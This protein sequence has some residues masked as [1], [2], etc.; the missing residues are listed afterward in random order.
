MSSTSTTRFRVVPFTALHA[1][2]IQPQKRQLSEHRFFMGVDWSAYAKRGSAYAMEEKGL[3]IA[4]AG[5]MPVWDGVYEAWAMIGSQ[6]GRAAMVRVYKETQLFLGFLFDDPAVRRV[7]TQVK[8]DFLAGHR[9][10][11]MLGFAEEG[12]LR[13]YGPDGS[14]YTMYSR[15]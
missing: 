1:T 14:D 8:T 15:V 2:L 7:Q 5:V 13:R 12:V 10:A 11:R 6:V 3:P 4:G 9:F